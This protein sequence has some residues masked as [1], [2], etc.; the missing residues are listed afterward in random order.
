M[1]INLNSSSDR[2]NI[3]SQAECPAYIMTQ[4]LI[5]QCNQGTRQ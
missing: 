4:M 1:T 3:K 5:W 2:G